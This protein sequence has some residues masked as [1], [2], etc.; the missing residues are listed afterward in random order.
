MTTI[1]HTAFASNWQEIVAGFLKLGVTAYGGPPMMGLK[2]RMAPHAM[3]DPMAVAMLIGTLIALLAWRIGALKLM[4]AGA[5]VGV[6][7]S[8]LL[9]LPS[10]RAVF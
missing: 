10:G 2:F 9:A 6:L 1:K 5:V 4:S 7:R 8:R 3:P